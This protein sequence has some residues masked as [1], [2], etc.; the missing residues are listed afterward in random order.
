MKKEKITLDN[1][2]EDLEF[3]A[4]LNMSR[5]P[6]TLVVMLLTL[7]F[8]LAFMAGMIVESFLTGLLVMV[9]ASVC[10]IVILI[11]EKSKRKKMQNTVR[12]VSTREEIS[13]SVEELS[14]VSEETASAP[15]WTG[16]HRR[17]KLN[18]VWHFTSGAEWVKPVYLSGFFLWS[19]EYSLGESGFITTSVAGNKFYYVSLQS[20]PDINFIYPCKFFELDEML[21]V[22]VTE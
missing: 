6:G 21:A 20:A 11:I 8:I 14:H 17:V 19:K 10:P 2:K 5:K 16:S 7:A 13:I 9:I 15:S 18:Y 22:D 1:I 12:S 3:F 4:D